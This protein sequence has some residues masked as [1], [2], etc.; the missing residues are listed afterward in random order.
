ME[1]KLESNKKLSSF[2]DTAV[3]LSGIAASMSLLLSIIY[4]YAYFYA[5]NLSFSDVPSTISDHL[6]SGLIW[7][8]TLLFCT[9]LAL[10]FELIT[11]RIEKGMSEDEIIE[12]S[13]DPQKVQKFREG[14]LKIMPWLAGL[15]IISY[16]LIGENFVYGLPIAFCLIWFRIAPWLNNHPRIFQRRS[17]LLRFVIFWLPVLIIY[18]Y[19][20]G[21]TDGKKLI[22]NDKTNCSIILKK[23]TNKQES[24]ILIKLLE[25]GILFKRPTENKIIYEKWDNIIN[26]NK[27]VDHSRYQGIIYRFLG[28]SLPNNKHENST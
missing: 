16:I 7:F 14:P 24:I 19:G 20:K 28:I 22:H 17:K 6:R 23:P 21:H 9:F 13:P 8:P 27:V 1:N 4:D 3:K 5:L 26:I 15:I 11:V 25:K 2:L 10:I 12:S 18:L